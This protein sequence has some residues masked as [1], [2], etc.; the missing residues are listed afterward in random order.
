MTRKCEEASDQ[1]GPLSLKEWHGSQFPKFSFCLI[2]PRIRAKEASNLEM[3]M[4][5]DE[6]SQQN[7]AFFS[8]EMKKAAVYQDRKH[9]EN[10]LST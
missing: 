9:L 10:N 5:T 3:W 4:D 8:H 7:L 2:Y 1:V 6:K